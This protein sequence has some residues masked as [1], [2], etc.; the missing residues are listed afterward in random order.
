MKLKKQKI[1]ILPKIKK[2][3]I[4]LN[5]LRSMAAHLAVT[6]QIINKAGS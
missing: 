5:T 1:N 2:P 4:L 6:F 3:E